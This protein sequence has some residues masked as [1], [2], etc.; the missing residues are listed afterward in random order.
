M[1]QNLAN[2]PTVF[3]SHTDWPRSGDVVHT[4]PIRAEQVQPHLSRY[5][6]GQSYTI[7]PLGFSS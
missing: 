1:A 4:E 7:V 3:P 5:A 6:S 2:M